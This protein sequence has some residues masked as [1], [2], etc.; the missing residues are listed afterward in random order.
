MKKRIF[1]FVLAVLMIASLL[2]AAALAADVV[3]SGTCGAEG[4]GSNLTW[5]LD[6]DGLLT[7]RGTGAME[8]Y[9]SDDAPWTAQDVKTVVI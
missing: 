9:F 2:P 4:D 5:T 7:I 1:S 3:A 8:N 6:S